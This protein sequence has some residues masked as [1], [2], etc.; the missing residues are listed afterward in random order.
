MTT[1]PDD[2]VLEAIADIAIID[3]DTHVVE[4][5]DLWTSRLPSRWHDLVPSVHWDDTTQEE[6]WF[7]AGERGISIGSS[8]MAGWAEWPPNSPRRWSE[9]DPVMWDASLR[10]R[11]MDEDGIAA[12]VLYPNV[13]VFGAKTI[14][15]LDPEV[16]LAIVRT[17]NDF[18]VEW[19][20]AEPGRYVP[21]AMLPF[22][23]AS[24][25][26]DEMVRCAEMGHRGVIFTQDPTYFGL[27]NLSDRHWDPMWGQAQELGLSINFHI[28]TAGLDVV[29]TFNRDDG[30]HA[31]KA[32][33]GTCFFMGNSKTIGQL[34]TGGVCHRFP[35]LQF[36]SV[37][38]GIG[39]I[40]FYI[41]SLDWQWRN[42]GVVHEHPE[43]DLLPSEY[44]KRQFYGCFWFERETAYDAIELLGADRVL[45][46]TDF[47]HPTSMTP[48]PAS[49]AVRPREYI[50]RD[51]G[52]LPR[53]TLRAILHDNA[54]RLYHL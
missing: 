18:L 33:S 13:A 22:W 11:M 39:W 24:L 44:F 15:R 16:Q 4:P 34:I 47:P 46:E 53:E 3:V 17:Y 2:A 45:Y 21:I 10:A 5:P 43:Y 31:N 36:V 50:A 20:G 26:A 52:A 42:A 32:L 41:D 29:S 37:E 48:G 49:S 51:L 14:L 38:S 8:A 40:P 25:I 27:P 1:I 7:L 23:D 19:G 28:A 6:A 30:K 54:A 9:V 35:D 12:Q